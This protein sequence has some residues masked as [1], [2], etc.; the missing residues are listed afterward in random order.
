MI[1]MKKLFPSYADPDRWRSPS[2][3]TKLQSS[4]WKEIRLKILKRDD[5]T[6]QYCGY[7]A[8]KYQIVDHIDGNPNNNED[9]NLQT[10][11]QMCNLIKHAGQGCVVKGIV[12]LYKESKYTQNDI[13]R[14]TR[15]MR[16][17]GKTDEEIIQFLG[18]ENKFPFKMDLEYLKGLCGFVTSRSS[19]FGDDMYDRWKDYH[20][21]VIK[22]KGEN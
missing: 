7:R 20:N 17:Q 16:D 18:L 15:E 4:D 12:E 1:V 13:I 3:K 5:F 22:K 14:I 2:E 9:N 11:C 6:C 8:E 10:V 21:S 19:R